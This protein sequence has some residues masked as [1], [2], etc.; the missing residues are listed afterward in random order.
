MSED[1]EKKTEKPSQKKLK[2]ARKKGQVPKSKEVVSALVLLVATVYFYL[3]W[4]S[5]IQQ[6]QSLIV[7]PSLFYETDFSVAKQQLISY[8]LSIALKT[9]VLPFVAI[10][11][12]ITILSNIFQFGFLFAIDP[13]MPKLEK[14]SIISGFGR[15]FSSKTVVETSISLLK[16]ILISLVIWYVIYVALSTF[17]NHPE[18]CDLGCYQMIFQ[19][20]TLKLVSL[21]IPLFILMAII[22]YM[23]QNHEFIKQQKMTK[24]EAKADFKNTEG[25]P[26]VKSSRK[27]FHFEMMYDDLEDRIKYSKIII[28]DYNKAV[29]LSYEEGMKLPMLLCKAS[30][31][32]VSK[33][34]SVGRQADIKIVEETTLTHILFED[35]E[36]DEYIPQETIEKVAELLR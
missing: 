27:S 4:D 33:M 2:D 12:V 14:I 35:G 22:D 3:F 6:L 25:D 16:I 24:E 8:M 21:L 20:L 28:T 32:M 11:M 17:P 5:I 29:A 36:I 26:F 9:I 31:G 23:V 18:Q 15:I 1:K 34:L 30:S 7:A 10:L 13:I 19:S